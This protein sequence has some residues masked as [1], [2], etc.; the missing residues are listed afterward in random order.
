MAIEKA[1]PPPKVVSKDFS[2]ADYTSILA[3][4]AKCDFSAPRSSS[5]A[6]HV[7]ALTGVLHKHINQA[8]KDFVPSKVSGGTRNK[9]WFDPA[10]YRTMKATKLAFSKL[11]L[12]RTPA[13]KA[14]YNAARIAHRK[15][16]TAAKS[17]H[18]SRVTERIASSSDPK[19]FWSRLNQ[20]LEKGYKPPIPG[21]VKDGKDYVSDVDKANV[22]NAHFASQADLHVPADHDTKASPPAPTSFLRSV[23]VT[24]R[25]VL[26]LLLSLDESK[27]TGSDKV[28]ASFLKAIAHILCR[29]LAHIFSLS[30]SEN[31]RVSRHVED[32]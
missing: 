7:H 25:K 2:K 24:H 30:L 11:Q 9:P 27:T 6:A 26:R 1:A 10:C 3:F 15:A 18:T 8:I 13:N 32:R 21:L 14:A 5:A 28:P 17:V 19:E 31:W 12:A 23:K 4:L 20:V 16:I 29:P 22:L